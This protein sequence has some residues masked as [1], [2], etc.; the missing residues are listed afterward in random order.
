MGAFY[1]SRLSR[2]LT[3]AGLALALA[4]LPLPEV[5][6]PVIGGALLFLALIDPI[7]GLAA[8]LLFVPAQELIILPGGLNAAQAA[9]LLT[10]TAWIAYMLS[11][12]ERPVY[13]G[14]LLPA[15]AL[16]IWALALSALLSP[17]SLTE[18]IRETSR[19]VVAMLAY[20]VACD[21][22]A[23]DDPARP[24]RAL[25]LISCL[26]LGTT[27]N[28]LF[29]LWQFVTGSGP[30]SFAIA[31]GFIRAYG[32]IGQPNSFAGS[33]NI[34][35][36]LAAG[37]FAAWLIH[38]LPSSVRH[39]PSI[40]Y[41]RTPAL[42]LS[43]LMLLLAALVASLSRGGWIGAAAGM[44]TIVLIT[45]TRLAPLQRKIMHQLSIAGGA[46]LLMGGLLG[47][48][49]L[50]PGALG[51]RIAGIA[52]NLRLFDV[53]TV[54]TTAANFAVVERM[55]HLQAAWAM[56][57]SYPFT[58]VGAGTYSL[59]YE[60]S[61][62]QAAYGIH[63]WYESRG[64]AHNYYL[65]IAAESGLAGLTAYFLLLGLITYQAVRSLQVA[66]GWL[67]FGIVNGSCGMIVAVAAHNLFENLHVLN[68]G[69]LMG[70][71]WGILSAV[72]QLVQAKKLPDER[73]E[74]NVN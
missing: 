5:L 42:L 60:G 58:G 2:I 50:L 13:A 43:A 57:S 34:A 71:I 62:G 37:L 63:P 14:R 45:T 74:Y 61:N 64:H 44:L 15:L 36:P 35:W 4:L 68:F 7:W 9:M 25:L 29:G 49:G 33:L 1:L 24:W 8:A 22:V 23:A 16:L 26:L 59:A 67:W 38:R 51:E 55:S 70:S 12:P 10:A 18:G 11:H 30:E 66:R 54:E 40:G 28:A 52:G 32:T 73:G 39:A 17:Y 72:E 20:L 69:V 27:T 48:S 41:Y 56:F 3:V 6:L 65:H 19:W 21:R 47:G 46:A 53:R 31:G